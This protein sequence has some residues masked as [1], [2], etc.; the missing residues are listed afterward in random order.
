MS[1]ISIW[2]CEHECDRRECHHCFAANELD[3]L[4]EGHFKQ[5]KHQFDNAPRP[6]KRRADHDESDCA[7]LYD[8]EPINRIKHHKQQ[9][10]CLPDV[11][12][13]LSNTI[14]SNESHPIQPLPRLLSSERDQS[15]ADYLVPQSEPKRSKSVETTSNDELCR[16]DASTDPNAIDYEA[17]C[18]VS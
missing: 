10:G 1:G 8:T 9:R 16:N 4:I 11:L 17:K 7:N 15:T 2:R 6:N 13:L 5:F 12:H 18:D 3:R 14:E